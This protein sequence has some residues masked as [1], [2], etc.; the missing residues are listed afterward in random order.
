[1]KDVIRIKR[2]QPFGYVLW[3]NKDVSL[4]KMGP[5]EGHANFFQSDRESI[6]HR[7]TY[8]AKSL[9][10]FCHFSSIYFGPSLLE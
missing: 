2:R 5:A 3:P 6:I 9:Q 10:L 4:A 8:C 1:V 7:I